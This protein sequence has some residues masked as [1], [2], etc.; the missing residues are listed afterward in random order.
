MIY[1]ITTSAEHGYFHM[2]YLQNG[3]NNVLFVIRYNRKLDLDQQKQEILF[4]NSCFS[5]D[6][7]LIIC[8]INLKYY[9]TQLHVYRH[10]PIFFPY[11]FSFSSPLPGMPTTYL[12]F[13][14]LFKIY[15]YLRLSKPSQEGDRQLIERKNAIFSRPHCVF[16]VTPTIFQ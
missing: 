13:H 12:K 15:Q 16:C 7:V 10:L 3:N 5:I 11:D 8:C 14:Y 1:I 4:A 9:S 2:L 6:R